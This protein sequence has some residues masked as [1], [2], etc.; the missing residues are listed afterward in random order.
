M[1]VFFFASNVENVLNCCGT[2]QI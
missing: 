1:N 2:Q